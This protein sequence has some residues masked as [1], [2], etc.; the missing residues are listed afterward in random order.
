MFFWPAGLILAL[1]GPYI[2]LQS[3]FRGDKMSLRLIQLFV[4]NVMLIKCFNLRDAHFSQMEIFFVTWNWK[5]R[6]QFQLQVNEKY[7]NSAGQGVTN[8]I[9]LHSVGHS[10][11]QS[12][13]LQIYSWW[14]TRRAHLWQITTARPVASALVASH[15]PTFR[16]HA[17]NLSWSCFPL[18]MP[19]SLFL[20]GLLADLFDRL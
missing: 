18:N 14:K 17:D 13:I 7:N 8:M 4:V 2:C 5:L 10:P 15:T 20:L 6:Q 1:L 11:E 3:L 19:D 16:A 12:Y 9:S